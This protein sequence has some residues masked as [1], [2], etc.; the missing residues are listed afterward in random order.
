MIWDEG[1]NRKGQ[2][3]IKNRW[4]RLIP[5]R[6]SFSDQIGIL[7]NEIAVFPKKGNN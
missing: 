6:G 4:Q 3:S 7:T 5:V 2:K 1:K